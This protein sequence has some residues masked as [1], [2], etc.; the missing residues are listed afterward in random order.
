[1]NDLQEPL[2]SDDQTKLLKSMMASAVA[3]VVA[4]AMALMGKDTKDQSKDGDEPSTSVGE[5][6]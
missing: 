4:K 5:W 3:N 1:M 6:P 2:F